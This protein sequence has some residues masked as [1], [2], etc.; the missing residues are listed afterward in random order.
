MFPTPYVWRIQRWVT[1]C[2]CPRG[3]FTLVKQISH[4][5]VCELENHI[6]YE[7]YQIALNEE[8]VTVMN[9]FS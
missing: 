6:P 3:P 5:Y 1:H 7:K 9:T 8:I 2:P 4:T